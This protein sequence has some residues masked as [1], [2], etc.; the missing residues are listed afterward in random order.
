MSLKY[1][2]RSKIVEDAGEI[3]GVKWFLGIKRWRLPLSS[4]IPKQFDIIIPAH[5]TPPIY[6]DEEQVLLK[7][8]SHSQCT[9]DG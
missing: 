2:N 6:D 4:G 9:C 7:F 5:Y 8:A 1:P 3:E